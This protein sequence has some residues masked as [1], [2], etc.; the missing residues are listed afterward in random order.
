MDRITFFSSEKSPFWTIFHID[1][2]APT[3]IFHL[4][5]SPLIHFFFNK[6]N[7]IL[8]ELLQIKLDYFSKIDV[9]LIIK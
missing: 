3:K 2:P 6:C 9:F 1:I 7:Q 4:S 8:A 5:F